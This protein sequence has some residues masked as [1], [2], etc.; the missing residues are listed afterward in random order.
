MGKEKGPDTT[1]AQAVDLQSDQAI[2]RIYDTVYAEKRRDE[3]WQHWYKGHVDIIEAAKQASEPEMASPDFQAR[4]WNDNPISSTGACSVS[5]DK[6]VQDKDL[7]IWLAKTAKSPL[8]SIQEERVKAL[9]DIYTQLCQRVERLTDRMPWLKILRV[10]AAFFP[11]DFSNVTNRYMLKQVATAMFGKLPNESPVRLNAR[12]LGRLTEVLGATDG[13]LSELALRGEFVWCLYETIG[14]DGQPDSSGMLDIGPDNRRLKGLGAIPDPL[15]TIFDVV[16]L[17]SE[18][19]PSRAAVLDFLLDRYPNV[20]RHSLN[21]YL[22]TIINVFGMVRLDGE[23]LELTEDGEQLLE[24]EQP[25]V[26]IRAWVTKVVGPDMLLWQLEHEGPQPRKRLVEA[27]Q[28]HYRGW[29][30]TFAPNCTLRYGRSFGVWESSE[31]GNYSLTDSG[32]IWAKR[33]PKQPIP[34][35]SAKPPDVDEEE[36]EILISSDQYVPP[37]LKEVLQYFSNTSLVVSDG[38][39]ARVHA[40]MNAHPSKHFVL[41]SGL[42]GTGK[43]QIAI[44][45]AGAYHRVKSGEKNPYALMVAV[46]P[47]WTDSTG[48]LGYVNPLTTEPTYVRTK[49]VSFLLSAN[50]NPKTPHFLILDE[51][52]LARVEYYFAPFLS[53]MEI[54]GPIVLHHEEENIDDVPPQIPWPSNLFIFGTVNMDETTHAFSDKVLD[55]AFTVEFWDVDLDAYTKRFAS[56]KCNADYPGDLLANVMTTLKEVSGHLFPIHQHF[57]YRTAGEALGFMK[58]IDG[59]LDWTAAMDQ[60]VFMKVLPKLR[61]QDTDGLRQ[62]LGN[63]STWAKSKGYAASA[64]KLQTMLDELRTTG[65]TRFWR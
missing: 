7:A 19:K 33:L 59:G 46:Q 54:C 25:D 8:P 43:T 64:Y 39:V 65:T 34:V 11:N 53:A 15:N 9:E 13:S 29:T 49:C 51:M 18:N 10:L 30:T 27:L 31:D 17:V 36:D 50:E 3:G 2:R 38:L 57:G 5:M 61:G 62:A 40:A 44:N 6:V 48:L 32:H 63:I 12:I 42:S 56:Q 47:D 45:Y 35:A 58:A 4:I 41:L 1:N 23:S 28:Q 22:L 16:S 52:N 14:T 60:M 24:T 20:K 37:T 55:R 26:V 21:R